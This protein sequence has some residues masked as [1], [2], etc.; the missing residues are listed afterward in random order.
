M[1]KK[2]DDIVYHKDLGILQ[3]ESIKSSRLYT[4]FELSKYVT[5]K[6]NLRFMI[7]K[8]YNI[9]ARTCKVTVDDNEERASFI[10]LFSLL[11]D[12]APVKYIEMYFDKMY[13]GMKRKNVII[14]E[15]TNGNLIYDGM[16]IDK[17]NKFIGVK[18]FTNNI[19]TK[20]ES[21]SIIGRRMDTLKNICLE[22]ICEL[23]PP[24]NYDSLP[25]PARL[26]RCIKE[27]KDIW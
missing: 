17:I 22:K 4:E 7:N 10:V 12:D 19:I 14:M 23:V 6:Y 13:H 1:A 18:V 24:N 9:I 25:V 20:R 27:F 15:S 3:K 16:V 5:I 26:V 11:G 8:V 2:I 21:I